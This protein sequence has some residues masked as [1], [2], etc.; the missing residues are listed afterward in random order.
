MLSSSLP[1]CSGCI[2]KREKGAYA[3]I[4]KG[5][6]PCRKASESNLLKH[7]IQ[8]IIYNA[9]LDTFPKL[10]LDAQSNGDVDEKHES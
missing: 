7:E 10:L 9:V 1:H 4:R 3:E 2:T 6:V 8:Q 5:V